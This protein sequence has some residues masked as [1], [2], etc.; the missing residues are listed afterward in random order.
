MP[1]RCPRVPPAKNTRHNGA[2][3]TGTTAALSNRR[4]HA[5]TQVR[6]G[7]IVAWIGVV[8]HGD[9][10]E[11]FSKSPADCRMPSGHPGR[12]PRHTHDA[13]ALELV[14]EG[15]KIR[16]LV[17]QWGEVADV[18][19]PCPHQ[20]LLAEPWEEGPKPLPTVGHPVHPEI[21]G[22][23]RPRQDIVGVEHLL[24][25]PLPF[26]RLPTPRHPQQLLRRVRARTKRPACLLVVAATQRLHRVEP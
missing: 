24:P 26:S 22:D 8:H 18:T 1:Q 21:G 10:D 25:T 19:G 6:S 14:Y 7:S 23:L 12:D 5:R 3:Q 9:I 20:F 11:C 15:A 4:G 2:R 16:I 13:Q 17:R